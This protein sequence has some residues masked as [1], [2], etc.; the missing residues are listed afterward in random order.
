MF[1]IKQNKKIER[2]LLWFAHGGKVKKRREKKSKQKLKADSFVK[3]GSIW[4]KNTEKTLG[5]WRKLWRTS[6][7][8]AKWCALCSSNPQSRLMKTWSWEFCCCNCVGSLVKFEHRSPFQPW[9][10]L[11][12]A[13]AH[14]WKEKPW[15]WGVSIFHRICSSC[16]F[17]WILRIRKCQLTP[18]FWLVF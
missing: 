1:F 16:Q 7:L 3:L 9:E 15:V 2:S 11:C 10:T 4:S 13:S 12:E 18:L 8:H 5:R 6:I 14:I 17:T